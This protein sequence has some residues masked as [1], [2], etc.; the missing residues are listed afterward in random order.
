MK[1]LITGTS[2]GIGEGLAKHYLSTG[3]NVYGIS[4]RS[5]AIESER[6]EHCILDLNDLLM[7]TSKLTTFLSD[8]PSLDLLVL[9]AGTLGE[10]KLMTSTSIE[11]LKSAM[12]INMWANKIIVD[13]VLQKFPQIEKVIAI[14]SGASI[15]GHKGWGAYALSKAA[16]NMLMKLYANENEHTKFYAFAPGLVDTSMQNYIC[17]EVDQQ[18][19]PSTKRIANARKTDLMPRPEEV[20]A[21]I[22]TAFEKLGD[23]KS[24]DFVDLRRM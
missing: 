15:N 18:E 7:D 9:N 6:Y 17:D 14:S 16:L 1:V 13:T 22:A 24:G 11:D 2:S 10:I 8:I 3:A 12:D 5:T 23:Y 20:S 21:K 19:F 4:R